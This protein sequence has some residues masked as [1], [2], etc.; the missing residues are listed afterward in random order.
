M[1]G[2]TDTEP[3]KPG[4]ADFGLYTFHDVVR[5]YIWQHREWARRELSFY[6]YQ[7][8][9]AQV[10]KLAALCRTEDGKRHPHQRRTPKRVLHLAHR[11]LQRSKLRPVNTFEELHDAVHRTIGGR[12]GIG[13][14]TVYDVALR[15]GAKLGKEPRL[16]FLHAG[17]RKGAKAL[18][19]AAGRSTLQIKELP[20]PFARL[21][22]REVEDCLCLYA[23][24]MSRIA[25]RAN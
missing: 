5:A 16:V 10:V 12:R 20:A 3:C 15:I 23:D 22:P 8:S 24:D 1:R 6:R 19:L 21:R 9:F 25:S 4:R 13:P 17:T 14:L 2:C 18:G 11:I 7:R